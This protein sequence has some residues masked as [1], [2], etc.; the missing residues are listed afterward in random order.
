MCVTCRSAQIV[1][2]FSASEEIVRCRCIANDPLVE[3]PVSHCNSYDDRHLPSKR[4]MEKIAWILLTKT[5]GRSIGFVTAKQF[6]AIEGDD[7]EITPAARINQMKTG[8]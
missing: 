2:G 8:G 1:R 5:A 3:F 6:L 7:G 4:D